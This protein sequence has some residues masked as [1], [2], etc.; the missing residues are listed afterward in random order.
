MEL[1]SESG[2][3][4]QTT[5]CLFICVWL[6]LLTQWFLPV[7]WFIR[8]FILHAPNMQVPGWDFHE[9]W[10]AARLALHGTVSQLPYPPTFLLAI[11]PV[12]LLPYPV[13]YASFCVLGI[14]AFVVMQATIAPGF[15]RKHLL[16]LGANPAM[17]IALLAGQNSLF[18]AAAAGVALALLQSNAVLAGACIASLIVKP[19]LGLLFPLALICGRYWKVLAW[20]AVW[21]FSIVVA[22]AAVFGIH[23]WTQFATHLSKFNG[24]YVEQGTWVWT[25]TLTVFAACRL[26]GL[27]VATSYLVHGLVAAPAVMVMAYLWIRHA[28]F[29]LRASALVIATM[30]VPP[31]VMFYEVAWLVIPTLLI[32]RDAKAKK[33]TPIEWMALIAASLM[34]L[35]GTFTR[36]VDLFPWQLTPAVLISLMTMVLYRHLATQPNTAAHDSQIRA[37]LTTHCPDA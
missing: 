26:N 19:Q 13:A 18:T 6:V 29:E 30:L 16:L 2:S 25:A 28:R 27:S 1:T 3:H 31:Y 24:S 36:W 37:S 12:G 5:G 17:S 23:A 22:S 34:P 9:F 21:T 4:R 10:L 7:V 15:A 8:S 33:P 20:S 32:M 11:A 35:Q 14:S